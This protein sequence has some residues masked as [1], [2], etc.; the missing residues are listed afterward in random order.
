MK[1]LLGNDYEALRRVRPNKPAPSS[2]LINPLPVIA[3]SESRKKVGDQM[4]VLLKL[5]NNRIFRSAEKEQ[6]EI[7]RRFSKTKNLKELM[8]KSETIL[9]ENPN[10]SIDQAINILLTGRPLG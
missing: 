10:Y 1:D 4:A 5:T 9:R 8:K 3:V 7:H 2:T 6:E